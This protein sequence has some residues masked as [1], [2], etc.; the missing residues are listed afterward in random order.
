MTSIELFLSILPKLGFCIVGIFIVTVIII[1][2]IK[3]LN[4]LTSKKG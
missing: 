4:A 1:L 3:L 2:C